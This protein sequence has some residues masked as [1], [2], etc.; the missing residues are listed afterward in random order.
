MVWLC[1]PNIEKKQNMSFK[2][3]HQIHVKSKKI[4]S[5]FMAILGIFSSRYEG[6]IFQ[7]WFGVF[8]G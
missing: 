1:K 6:K 5:V 7:M 4:D 8:S 3:I 2:P